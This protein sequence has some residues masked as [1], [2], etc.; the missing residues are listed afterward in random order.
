MAATDHFLTPPIIAEA[1]DEFGG[2]GLDPCS[3]P[4]A[5]VKARRRIWLP[6]DWRRYYAQKPVTRLA[7]TWADGLAVPWGAQGLVFVNPPY[8][9]AAPWVARGATEGDEVIQLVQVDTSTHL[10]HQIVF[11]QYSR[12]L[13]WEGR[14]TYWEGAFRVDKEAQVISDVRL[15]QPARPATGPARFAS[16]LLYRGTRPALFQDVF[17]GCGCVL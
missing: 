2:V 1:L 7:I 4:W 13:F 6:D 8:G 14:L 12:I 3:N 16:A 9:N 5:L 10:W 17:K 15:D 11:P